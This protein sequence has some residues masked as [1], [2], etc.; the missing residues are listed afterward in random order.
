MPSNAFLHPF[1]PLA[2]YCV[3][4]TQS[5]LSAT[6]TRGDVRSAAVAELLEKAAASE[7]SRPVGDE[8]SLLK[9]SRRYGTPNANCDGVGVCDGVNEREAVSV[10][11]GEREAVSDG[12]GVPVAVAPVDHVMDIL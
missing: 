4:C 9:V 1:E 3:C 12:V 8:R 5:P 7:M 11:V 10:S 6:F 2:K